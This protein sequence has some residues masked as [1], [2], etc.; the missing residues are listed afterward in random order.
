M[1]TPY[2]QDISY[3]GLLCK[4]CP[5]FMATLEP[6]KDKQLNMRRE[7]VDITQ[8]LYNMTFTVEEITDC[9]GC[10][11]ETGP[12]FK[13]CYGCKIRNCVRARGL[14]SC[15]FCDDYPCTNLDPVFKED[16]DAKPRL[17]VLRAGQQA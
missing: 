1:N 16:K 11:S 2:Q 8:K 6:D 7:I 4:G 5:I 3:C 15:A 14:E 9:L 17:D 12:I 13:T 10:R